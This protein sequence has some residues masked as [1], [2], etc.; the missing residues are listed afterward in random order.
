M[1]VMINQCLLLNISALKKKSKSHTE[2][3]QDQTESE[4]DFVSRIIRC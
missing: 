3:K 1:T 2:K 4:M